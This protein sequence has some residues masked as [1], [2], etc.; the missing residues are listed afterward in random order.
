MT[1]AARA[2]NG[3]SGTRGTSRRTWCARTKLRLRK[4]M[5][6]LTPARTPPRSLLRRYRKPNSQLSISIQPPVP[7]RVPAP[8]P[9]SAR[10]WLPHLR[11]RRPWRRFSLRR[12]VRRF[13]RQSSPSLSASCCWRVV[14]S[15]T[16]S[17]PSPPVARLPPASLPQPQA[18]ILTQSPVQDLVQSQPRKTPTTEPSPVG[19][20]SPGSSSTPP[21]WSHGW[22]P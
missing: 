9:Y 16:R 2:T 21:T 15:D 13:C 22:P 14:C 18:R 6:R 4:P 5:R 8:R 12:R 11:R 3:M 10:A 19:L 17:L 7:A 1:L 20:T